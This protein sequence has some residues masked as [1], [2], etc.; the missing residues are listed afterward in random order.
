MLTSREELERLRRG[1]D[2]PNMPA[3]GLVEGLVVEADNPDDVAERARTVLGVVIEGGED[4]LD[5]ENSAWVQRLPG[6]FVSACSPPQSVDE[7]EAWLARWRALDRAGK[8]AAEA[9]LGWTLVDWLGAVD[10][11]TRA[12]R[13]WAYDG[14]RVL[15][16]VDGWPAP[17]ESLIW[18]LTAA[19]ARSV[20]QAASG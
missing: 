4:G 13:W 18:L 14:T 6:W 19:G 8:A 12:W 20:G 2:A 9:A 5:P 3:P 11:R 16:L 10:S 7:R 15:V 17:L 1:L